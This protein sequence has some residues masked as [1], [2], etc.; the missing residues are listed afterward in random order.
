MMP[1]EYFD[2]AYINFDKAIL[3]GR[4]TAGR[5]KHGCRIERELEQVLTDEQKE[6]LVDLNERHRDEMN[7]LL[8]SF[9]DRNAQP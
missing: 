3:H 5:D 6:A 8:S 1:E 7:A 9:A 2:V 4:I